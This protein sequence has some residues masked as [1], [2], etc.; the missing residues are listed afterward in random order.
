MF[1]L[2]MVQLPVFKNRGLV[3]LL[4]F[5]NP[6]SLPSFSDLLGLQIL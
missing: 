5:Q 4:A 6:K 3:Y 1:T 2:T